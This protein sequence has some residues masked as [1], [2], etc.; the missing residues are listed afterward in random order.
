MMKGCALSIIALISC[1]SATMADQLA[2]AIAAV[3]ATP[4]VACMVQDN[5]FIYGV[6]QHENGTLTGLGEISGMTALNLGENVVASAGGTVHVLGSIMVT[7]VDG[8]TSVGGPCVSISEAIAELLS[9]GEFLSA[10]ETTL[11]ENLAGMSAEMDA[12]EAEVARR[13][14]AVDS[15]IAEKSRVLDEREAQLKALAERQSKAFSEN[16]A[17]LDAREAAIS[18]KE[19]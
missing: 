11:A 19:N 18:A 8:D 3:E 13:E 12:R 1:T 16:Q 2:D 5:L 7:I 4:M 9:S 6:K 10:N 14:A 15:I 17:A